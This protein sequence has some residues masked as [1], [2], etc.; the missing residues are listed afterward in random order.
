MS[1]HL[2]L[3]CFACMMASSALAF[4]PPLVSSLTRLPRRASISRAAPT[5]MATPPLG[6]QVSITLNC[7]N[8]PGVT[9]RW[10]ASRRCER[11]LL[12]PTEHWSPAGPRVWSSVGLWQE[13]I[14]EKPARQ[15]GSR[16]LLSQGL[17][18]GMHVPGIVR[19]CVIVKYAV[20]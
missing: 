11:Y 6:E 19:V 1:R 14:P 3:C 10:V 16:I 12:L 5:M 9:G 17:Y 2:L 18:A 20:M 13:S 4:A 15:M 7:M 8:P